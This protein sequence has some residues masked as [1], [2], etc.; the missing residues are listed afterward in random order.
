VSCSDRFIRRARGLSIS[1]H[2]SLA[3]I[4]LVPD[5]DRGLGSRPDESREKHADHVAFR[6]VTTQH[7]GNIPSLGCAPHRA[8]GQYA[9]T[10]YVFRFWQKFFDP[11]F[12]RKLM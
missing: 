12:R 8:G 4:G 9:T 2:R 10:C 11:S 6:T 5:P 1:D 3:A 7:G